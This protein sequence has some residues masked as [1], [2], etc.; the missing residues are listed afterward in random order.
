M[1][2]GI[3]WIVNCYDLWLGHN[4]GNRRSKM[5]RALGLFGVVMVSSFRRLVWDLIFR[6]ST[7]SAALMGVGAL[8][9]TVYML[10]ISYVKRDSIA[11]S[12]AIS[13]KKK[14]QCGFVGGLAWWCVVTGLLMLLLGET[15]FLTYIAYQEAMNV[16]IYVAVFLGL[17]LSYTVAFPAVVVPVKQAVLWTIAGIMVTALV[18][19]WVL[20]QSFQSLAQGSAVASSGWGVAVSIAVITGIVIK[21]IL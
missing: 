10:R 9:Y 4:M 20:H 6:L 3:D 2:K 13:R 5:Y 14:V 21:V 16:S 17:A 12:L 7:I 8:V 19:A 15:S 11:Y 18:F 1:G